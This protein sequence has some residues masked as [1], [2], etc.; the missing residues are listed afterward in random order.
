MPS[1]IKSETAGGDFLENLTKKRPI[2]KLPKNEIEKIKPDNTHGY[3]TLGHPL[4][5]IYFEISSNSLI[6]K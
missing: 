3:R 1:K 4:S 6:F 2:F 5:R